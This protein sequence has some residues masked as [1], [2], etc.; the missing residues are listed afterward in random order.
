MDMKKINKSSVFSLAGP[1]SSVL[2]LSLFAAICLAGCSSAQTAPQ[3]SESIAGIHTPSEGGETSDDAEK[4][5]DSTGISDQENGPAA[6]ENTDSS[7]TASNQPETSVSLEGKTLSIIGDSISTFDGYI[8]SDYSIYYPRHGEILTVEETW[9]YQVLENTGMKLGGNASYSNS[10]VA[11]DSTSSTDGLAAC[12]WRR[13][14]DL[15]ASDG[16]SPDVILLFTGINDFLHCIPLG[17]FDGTPSQIEEGDIQDFSKAYELMLQKVLALYPDASVY[18]CTLTET[19]AGDEKEPRSYPS[20]NKNGNVIADFNDTIRNIAAAYNLPLIDVHECG[21]T[22]DN[23]SDY[24]GDGLHPN[25]AG[26]SLIADYITD[27][28]LQ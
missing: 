22:Y 17:N 15:K 16:S 24:T 25:P 28:L 12:S 13:V 4:T 5:E 23:L 6:S 20:T 26:A 27:F 11:G 1:K 7:E 8:P 9:W 19:D 3:Q 14:N 21:I 18:L 2:I 10:T